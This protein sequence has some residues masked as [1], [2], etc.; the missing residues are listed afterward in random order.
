M[1]PQT[2]SADPIGCMRCSGSAERKIG[3][4]SSKFAH[5]PDGPKPQNT[6][7]SSVD[8][9]IDVV[10]GRD[11]QMRLAEMQKRQTHKRGVIASNNTTGDNLS[12]LSDGDYFVMTEQERVAAKKARLANQDAMKRISKVR[13]ERKQRAPEQAAS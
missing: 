7:A 12:R 6:G 1:L 9:D 10:I 4:G 8:H 13:R 3:V 11:S 2:A 5:R